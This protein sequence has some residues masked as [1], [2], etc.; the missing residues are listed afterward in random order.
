MNKE[1][2]DFIKEKYGLLA[3]W[4]V[5]AEV[6]DSPKSNMGDLSIFDDPSIIDSLNENIV[7]VGLNISRGSIKIPLA[8]FHDPSPRATDFK[9]RFALKSTPYWGGYMTDIIK[10]YDEIDSGKIPSFLKDNPK[11]ETENIKAFEEELADLES[12][13]PL[14]AAFGGLA[15]KILKRNFEDKYRILPLPHYAN[16]E[17]KEKYRTKVINVL[18]EN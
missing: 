6:G 14:I 3:S 15:F 2:V 5:W 10:N 9:T 11:V 7:F 4:A 16:Y 12:Q 18:D 8:N 13:D 1:K 17:S